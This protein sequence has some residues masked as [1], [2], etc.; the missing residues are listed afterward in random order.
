MVVNNVKSTKRDRRSFM[1]GIGA[2]TVGLLTSGV[3]IVAG[4]TDGNVRI[5]TARGG[6]KNEVRDTQKV[7]SKWLANEQAID[8]VH[9]KLRKKLLANDSVQ[10]VYLGVSDR[11]DGGVYYSEPVISVK[12]DASQAEFDRLP[13]SLAEAGVDRPKQAV[14]SGIQK[15]RSRQP[16][17]GNCTG[18]AH[19][20]SF[21]GGLYVSPGSGY[22]TGGFR[23]YN[24]GKEYLLTARH[25]AVDGCT[26]DTSAKL[27]D[28]NNELI[29]TVADGHKNHDWVVVKCDSS[30]NLSNDIWYDGGK[31]IAVSG[32]KTNNGLK[33]L[34]GQTDAVQSQGVTTGYTTG[35]VTGQN[36][37][38]SNTDAPH[39]CT[40]FIDNGV[41]VRT[42]SSKGDSGGPTWEPQD[43]GTAHVVTFLSLLYGNTT[44]TTSDCGGGTNDVWS[45][46]VGWPIWRI[47]NNNPYNV[48]Y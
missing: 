4:S 20:Y 33:A 12:Y 19:P 38:G 21:D 26:I 25:V 42:D 28:K 48:G 32:H 8:T 7:P 34:K 16:R 45:A 10:A 35:T 23:M 43:D 29:G 14:V 36:F 40:R 37:T 15:E 46:R 9:R 30:R 3:S 27:Y 41:R 24:D 22:G 47:V 11:T 5:V 39:Y 18:T 31:N 6:P 1:K 13:D 44:G 17:H 2:G